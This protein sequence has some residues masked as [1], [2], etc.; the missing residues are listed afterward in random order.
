MTTIQ[1]NQ[2]LVSPFIRGHLSPTRIHWSQES[3]TFGWSVWNVLLN[4]RIAEYAASNYKSL[5][6]VSGPQLRMLTNA[7]ASTFN[8][9]ST[10]AW[11]IQNA[12]SV[13]HFGQGDFASSTKGRVRMNQKSAES[14]TPQMLH[15]ILSF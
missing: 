11:H 8:G 13:F 9:S 15:L 5:A 4:F 1:T 6:A 12:H 3:S 14:L 2:M 10:G 7:K